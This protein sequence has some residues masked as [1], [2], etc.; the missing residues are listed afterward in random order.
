M[1][2]T[3]L[4]FDL[5]GTLFDSETLSC[6]AFRETLGRLVRS[7]MYPQMNWTEEMFKAAIGM[8]AT[9]I[10]ETL[11]PGADKNVVEYAIKL[12]EEVEGE[13]LERE[14]T[15]Y[16]GV[17]Q[18]LQH[19]HQQGHQL[20]IASNGGAVYVPKVLDQ[21]GIRH[22]FTG[23]YCAGINRTESKV[24]LVSLL[25]RETGTMDAI[26]IGDRSSDISAGKANK[27]ITVGCSYGFGTAA[28]L[29]E[30]DYLITEF[31]QLTDIVSGGLRQCRQ[32]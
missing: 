29:S 2:K 28:E 14:G 13:L 12:M 8:T 19:F 27:L 9:E 5:D 16:P 10:F 4:I 30:A 11:L 23:I 7:E 26:M 31:T 24:E 3:I 32:S 1:G 25:L 17:K 22:L 15:L 20:Y 6:I 21:Q 18:T